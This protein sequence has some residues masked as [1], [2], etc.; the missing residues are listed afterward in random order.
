MAVN[1]WDQQLFYIMHTYLEPA[2][3]EFPLCGL[4]R[5]CDVGSLDEVRPS[6]AMLP[7]SRKISR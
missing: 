5:R 2:S 7:L 3:L 6:I 1:R 4:E